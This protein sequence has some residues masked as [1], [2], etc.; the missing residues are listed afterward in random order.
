[1][2]RQ[3]LKVKLILN[4]ELQARYRVRNSLLWKFV[5]VYVYMFNTS[6]SLN[7]MLLFC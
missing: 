6:M 2:V 5:I 7:Q 1:M 4:V 3:S